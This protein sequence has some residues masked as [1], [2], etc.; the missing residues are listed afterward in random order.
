MTNGL[1]ASESKE[2]LKL[3][4]QSKTQER[5]NVLETY[6]RDEDYITSTGE[7]RHARSKYPKHIDFFNAGAKYWERALIAANRVGKTFS[8]AYEVA[9][10]TTGLYP[11]WWKGRIFSKPTNWWIVGKTNESTRDVLQE[12]LLGQYGDFG[13][14]SIPKNCILGTSPRSGV[15]KAIS[16]VQIKHISGGVSEI[17]FKSY[18]QGVESFMGTTRDGIVLDEEPPIDIYSECLTRTMTV[19]GLVLMT[20]TPLE[21]MSDI[22]M[23]F[24]PGGK[25]PKF[26]ENLN[27]ICETE[28]SRKFNKFTQ[29]ITWD[30]V[31]HLSE[32]QKEYLWENTPHYLRAAR[33]KGIPVVGQGRVYPINEE[34][35]VVEPFEIP[36]A[37]K[38]IYGFDVGWQ[39]TAAIWLAINPDDNMIYAYSE[40]YRGQAEP[41]VHAHSVRTRGD[42]IYG[43][44]DPASRGRNQSDGLQLFNMYEDLGL[45]LNKAKNAVE[46]GIYNTFQLLSSGKCKIFSTLHNF[47][48]EFRLYRYDNNG[49]IVK[50]NDH[51][52]DAFRYAIMGRENAISFMETELQHN[53]TEPLYAVLN[54]VTGY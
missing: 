9:L 15:P 3:M 47:L 48:Q 52:M 50:V 28:E 44:I 41:S 10:H 8:A 35:I 6:F 43:E 17:G 30:D 2:L 5:Y 32:Q 38:R 36:K 1:N 11:K 37:W 42:W 34:E 19:K 22:V 45:Y 49:Q 20:F 18:Q 31:P 40:Y 7:V 54:S 27:Y 53:T 14:G 12:G 46:S 4:E 33:S 51:L 23:S 21:G 26:D 24:L 13:S 39:R 25:F 29:C 16:T